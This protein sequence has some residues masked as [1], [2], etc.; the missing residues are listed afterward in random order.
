MTADQ[1][2]GRALH[3]DVRRAHTDCHVTNTGRGK[4]ADQ[5]SRTARRYDRAADMG[6]D[7]RDH[8][9]DMHVGYACRRLSYHRETSCCCQLK[10][11]TLGQ[12]RPVAQARHGQAVDEFFVDKQ[13]C[14]E[15]GPTCII[16]AA[17]KQRRR[18]AHEMS[19]S[20]HPH[21]RFKSAMA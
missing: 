4:L 12:S 21:N 13:D 15:R 14:F 2:S 18:V 11:S 19:C 17:V 10:P 6:H 5:N 1:D 20:K 8:G 3:D 7:A 9:A 16:F